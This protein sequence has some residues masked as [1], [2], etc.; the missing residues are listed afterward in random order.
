M[1]PRP[2]SLESVAWLFPGQG[3]QA[4]GMGHDLYRESPAARHL[5]DLADQVLAFPLTDLLFRGPVETLQLTVHAQPAI[6]AVSLAAFA[7]FGEAWAAERDQPLPAPA[8]VAGH[9]VGEYAALVASGAADTATGLRLVQE[10]ARLMQHAGQT[11]PGSMVAVLGLARQPVAEACRRARARIPGSFVDVANHNA[12]TQVIITGDAAG[13]V[14]ATRLCQEAGARR[15]LPLAVS[16]P[17]HSAGM[18]SAVEPLGRAVA[19]AGLGDAT[20]PLVGN[21]AARPLTA[22]ND[23]RR[24]L[25]QQVASPVLWVD[26]VQYMVDAGVRTY[27]EFGAGQMLANLVQRH[28]GDL[29][30]MAVG[31]AAAARQAVSWLAMVRTPR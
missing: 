19:A 15:C 18:A 17:F 10:R 31:E 30:A 1:R 27:V 20:I 7:A 23:L 25:V 6:M 24:E 21:V 5:L 22:V 11:C 26:S 9:S 3:T 29:R 13:L 28:S 2:E 4:A 12:A 14:E 16:A 8:F